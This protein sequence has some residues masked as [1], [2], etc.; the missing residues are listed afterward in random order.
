MLSQPEHIRLGGE[1]HELKHLSSVR[2]RK[3]SDSLSSGE[4]NGKSLKSYYVIAGMRCNM[5]VVGFDV[6]EIPI[7]TYSFLS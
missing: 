5:V 6:Q 1:R 4:R 7:L 2:K 3:Q